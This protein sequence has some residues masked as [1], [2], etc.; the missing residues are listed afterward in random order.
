VAENV[1]QVLDYVAREEVNAGIVY[2]TDAQMPQGRVSAAA[3]APN[4]D[5]APILYPLAVT[6][7]SGSASA[8]KGFVDITNVLTRGPKR[9]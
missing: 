6:R 4:R 1:R 2:A 5:Y 7:D 8:A 3:R 9:A